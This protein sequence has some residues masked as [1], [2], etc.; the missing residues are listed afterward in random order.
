MKP[1][2]KIIQIKIIKDKIMKTKKQKTINLVFPFCILKKKKVKPN[3]LQKTQK[4]PN[5]I[6]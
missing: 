2:K 6:N 4:I 3:N 1:F 5:T